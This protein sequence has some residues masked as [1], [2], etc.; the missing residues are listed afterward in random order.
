MKR[1]IVIFGGGSLLAQNFI[2]KCDTSENKLVLISRNKISKGNLEFN[3]SEINSQIKLDQ[4]SFK[5][6]NELVH[7]NTVFI[8]FAWSGGP[9]NIDK[10][11]HIWTSNMNIIFNFLN[12]CKIIL[13]EKIIFLSSAGALYP[14]N[15]EGYNF[16]E[17]DIPSPK[18]IYGKQKLISEKLLTSFS[19]VYNLDLTILRIASAYGFDKRF[20][21]QGVINKWLYSA[22]HNQNLKLYNSKKSEINFISFD[23]ISIAILLSLEN[24]LTGIFNIGTTKSILLGEVFE[25]IIKITSKKIILEEI[26]NNNN[27]FFNIDIN[28]FFIKTGVKFNL[29][30]NEDIRFIY[31]S[32]IKREYL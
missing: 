2:S 27:R 28:K 19:E 14:D 30:L 16:T 9:R 17:S 1:N 4:F 26:N 3:L 11:M 31:D 29:N 22:I 5:I 25:E 13:P 7:N 18:T 32:I 23:Q 21:D 20:S 10:E 12:L 15:I 24:D 6:Q 8:L